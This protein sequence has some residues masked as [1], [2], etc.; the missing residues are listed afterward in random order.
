MVIVRFGTKI[1]RLCSDN[2]KEY[3]SSQLQNFCRKR[4]IECEYTAPYTPEQNG[5]AERINRT[6]LDTARSMMFGT[7][8]SKRIWSEAV[9][10]VVYIINR[11]PPIQLSGKTPAEMWFGIKPDLSK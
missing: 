5:V 4:G 1:N 2:G 11:R 7:K 6:I 3:I 10:T 8:L 9:L